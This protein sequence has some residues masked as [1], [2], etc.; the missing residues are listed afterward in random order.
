[1]LAVLEVVV[2]GH[3]EIEGMAAGL[4]WKTWAE[5]WAECESAP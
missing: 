1:V 3:S 5:F 4:G 2:G